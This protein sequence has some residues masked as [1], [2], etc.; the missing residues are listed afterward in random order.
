MYDFELLRGDC[1]THLADLR[2]DSFDLCLTDPPYE[3]GFMG[4]RWDATGIA[5]QPETWAA[6]LRVLKPGAHLLA[7]G[8]TRTYH[9]MVCAIEDAGFEIRDSIHWM[10]G[11]GFPKSHDVSKAM[12]RAAG[13]SRA[14]IGRGSAGIAG[15]TGEHSGSP[16]S[17]GYSREYDVTAPATDLAR[18]WEGW[19]TAL[20]PA[21]EPI[22][23]AR[24]PLSENSVR[25]NVERWGTGALNIAE[26]RVGTA[27]AGWNGSNG[28][29]HTHEASRSG[30]L[31]AGDPRP[32]SGRWPANV[33]F[34]HA[35]GCGTECTLDCPVRILDGQSGFSRSRM[36]SGVGSDDGGVTFKLRRKTPRLRGHED[37]GGASRFFHTFEPDAPFYYCPKP[38]SGERE[39][40]CDGLPE[41]LTTGGRETLSPHQRCETLRRNS[42]PTVKPIRL[43][44][45]LIKLC[46]L[47]GA[48]IL[49]PFM[50]SGS[51][52]VAA[53][54]LRRQFTGI[55]LDDEYLGIAQARTHQAVIEVR[56][57]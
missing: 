46:T 2:P 27:L 53:G 40:G 7:F 34:S 43:L 1:R 38:S 37:A 29:Q 19:G 26:S 47:P 21:H 22:V 44:E 14:V 54:N 15:G 31:G 8:G 39:A 20:K 17:Y 4:K 33:L 51:T 28:F 12:D 9:R 16:G 3:L 11:S 13:A 6:V 56:R 5:F 32:A 35:P 57:Q 48:R 41:C 52:G 10:Y 49:D 24:K 30:G 23:V 45:Y 36:V 50:G 55:E 42:H 25:A 18:A